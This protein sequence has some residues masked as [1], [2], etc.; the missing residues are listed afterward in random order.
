M[1][2]LPYTNSHLDII[3]IIAHQLLWQKWIQ[4]LFRESPQPLVLYWIY[5]ARYWNFPHTMKI[6]S[7]DDNLEYCFT[8]MMMQFNKLVQSLRSKCFVYMEL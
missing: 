4:M 1:N 2:N 8:K 7:S 3:K 5:K 6:P